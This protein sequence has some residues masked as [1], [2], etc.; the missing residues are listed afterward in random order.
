MSSSSLRRLLRPAAATAAAGLLAVAPAAEAQISGRTPSYNGFQGTSRS[1][2]GFGSAGRLG[3]DPL[4]TGRGVTVRPGFG[5]GFGGLYGGGFYGGGLYGGGYY[6]LAP[7]GA[8]FVPTFTSVGPFGSYT[9][10]VPYGPTVA[11]APGAV[12]V[13]YGPLGYGGVGSYGYGGLGLGGLNY[14]APVAVGVGAAG[15][16]GL[17]PTGAVV[18]GNFGANPAIAEGLREDA[19]RW[20]GAV[21]LG[22]A[23]PLPAAERPPSE[24]ELADSLREQRLGDEAFAALDYHAAARRYRAAAEAA[25]TRGEPLYRLAFARIATGDYPEAGEALRRALALNP[26]LPTTGP[27]LAD[28]WGGAAGDMGNDLARTEAVGRLAEHARGDVRDPDRLF[29]LAAVMHA[30]GDSRARDIF[31]AAWR[32]T[33]GRPWLRAYLDPVAVSP[34]AADAAPLAEDDPVLPAPGDEA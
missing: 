11:V 23:D 18:G 19:E 7:F 29:L 32:L 6:G 30:G 9:G 27:T 10:Y 4:A 17:N 22:D 28:L 1:Y 16:A 20:R 26:S 31:E 5:T 3:T 12:G 25:P 24:R 14:G 33:G 21:N 2:G 13:G 8:G 34:A 15:A